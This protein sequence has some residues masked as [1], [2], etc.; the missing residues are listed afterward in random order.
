MK[1]AR[2]GFG[3]A[4]LA[5]ALASLWAALIP[6]GIL[7]GKFPDA[8]IDLIMQV[9]LTVSLPAVGGAGLLIGLSFLLFAK[10]KPLWLWLPPLLAAPPVALFT[11][12]ALFH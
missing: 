2:L 3:V 8:A 11:G 1:G 7:R 4:V 5:S 10:G 6:I 9:V 12:S